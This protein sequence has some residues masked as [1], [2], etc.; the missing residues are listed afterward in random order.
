[1]PPVLPRHSWAE[2]PEAV[3]R[4]ASRRLPEQVCWQDGCLRH[5]R[6]VSKDR[7]SQWRFPF[8]CLQQQPRLIIS[9]L[10]PQLGVNGFDHAVVAIFEAQPPEAGIRNGQ[11]SL[12]A[13]GK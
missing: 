3:G 4:S 2:A 6:R 13:K 12:L 9:L 11:V 8:V 7:R 1:M 10:K 5:P